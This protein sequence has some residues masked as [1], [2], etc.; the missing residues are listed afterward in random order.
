MKTAEIPIQGMTCNHCVHAVTSALKSL[1]G[2]EEV[3]LTLQDAK[4]RVSY[5]ESRVNE[6]QMRD[7]IVEEGYSAA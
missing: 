7:A 6:Q 3:E 5:D 2:V 1:P 4:A